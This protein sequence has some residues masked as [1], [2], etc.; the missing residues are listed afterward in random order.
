M[1]GNSIPEPRHDEQSLPARRP[2]SVWRRVRLGCFLIFWLL[3]I[4]SPCLLVTLASVGQL[5]IS[6][7]VLPG[8]ELRVWL[9]MEVDHRGLGFSGTALLSRGDQQCLQTDVRYWLW[10]GQQQPLSYCDCYQ[11]GSLVSTQSGVCT[12]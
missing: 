1:T 3:F 8:Q 11:D 2:P 5:S 9:I 12:P 10:Q 4:L 6:Q 7:G